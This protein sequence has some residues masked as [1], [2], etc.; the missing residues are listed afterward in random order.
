MGQIVELAASRAVTDRNHEPG[1]PSQYIRTSEV[2]VV[3]TSIEATLAA[4]RVGSQLAEALA[5]PLT[6]VHFRAVPYGI[7]LDQPTGESP[8]ETVAFMD[9]LKSHGLEVRLRVFLCRSPR[10]AIR[11]ALR[12]HSLVLLGGRRS[13]WPGRATR[14]RRALEAAGHFVLFVDEGRCAA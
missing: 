1:S 14:W 10:R 7:A 2:Y 11:L 12:G 13:W 9:R 4:V 6:L 5:A 8:A 3:F